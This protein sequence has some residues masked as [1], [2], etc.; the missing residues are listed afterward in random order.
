MIDLGYALPGGTPLIDDKGINETYRGLVEV[1][2][3]LRVQAYIKFL[4]DRQLVNELLASVLGRLVGL[5][6]PRA[7]L[8]EVQLSDYPASGFLASAGHPKSPAFAVEAISAHSVLRRV[9]LQTQEAR[10]QMLRSWPKW[11]EAA[12]FDDWIANADRHTGNVLVGARGEVWLID[13]S[14]CFTGCQWVPASLVPD[15]VTQNQLGL[16]MNVFL[17]P[18][19][20]LMALQACYK[21]IQDFASV[22][23]VYA[24]S[25]AHLESYAASADLDALLQFVAN[26]VHSASARMCACVGMPGL[27]FG[28]H[29]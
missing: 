10:E 14:H 17:T 19:E 8:V 28:A 15:I 27:P 4:P 7:F 5:P 13:H 16:A 22:D 2:G 6:L 25:L 11:Y 26:R 20:K 18:A 9:D 3:G 24:R 1:A 29:P 21:A 12:S 23:T